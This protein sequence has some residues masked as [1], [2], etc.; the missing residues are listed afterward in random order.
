VELF[1]WK[2]LILNLILFIFI[3]IQVFFIRVCELVLL[4]VL[5]FWVLVVEEGIL[6]VHQ[7]VLVL[8]GAFGEELTRSV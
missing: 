1:I 6:I 8:V 4:G 2:F 5:D 7:H 3:V